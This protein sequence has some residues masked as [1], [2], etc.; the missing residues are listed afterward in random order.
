M[1]QDQC[2][3]YTGFGAL[4]STLQAI[5]GGVSSNRSYNASQVEAAI[6]A[7]EAELAAQSIFLDPCAKLSKYACKQWKHAKA[8]LDPLG[9]PYLQVQLRVQFYV[10]SYLFLVD[11][12]ARLHY[13]LQLRRNLLDYTLSTL[14]IE[15]AFLLASIALQADKG[16]QANQRIPSSSN[17]TNVIC[18]SSALLPTD[19]TIQGY[20]QPSDYL[21]SWLLAEMGDEYVLRHLPTMHADQSGLTSS[22]AQLL[23]IKEVSEQAPHNLHMYRLFRHS[24]GHSHVSHASDRIWLGICSTGVHLFE[25]DRSGPS[26][27]FL[28]S[29]L[30]TF[31]WPD[32]GKL[33]FEKRKF[34]IRS[35]GYP[36]RKFTYFTCSEEMAKHL[37]WLCR[38]SH[39]FQLMIAPRL[40]EMKRRENEL[41]RKRYRESYI[42]SAEDQTK[43]ETS[44]TTRR[45]MSSSAATGR[46][47]SIT[48]A[49]NNLLPNSVSMINTKL[50][51]PVSTNGSSVVITKPEIHSPPFTKLTTNGS[52]TSSVASS[53]HQ[54]DCQSPAL[55]SNSTPSVRPLLHS[56]LPVNSAGAVRSSLESLTISGLSEPIHTAANSYESNIRRS[57]SSARSA[58]NGSYSSDSAFVSCDTTLRH[59][60]NNIRSPPLAQLQSQSF[61]QLLADAADSAVPTPNSIPI[62][63]SDAIQSHLGKSYSPIATATSCSALSGLSPLAKSNGDS[64]RNEM[65]KLRPSGSA[66]VLPSQPSTNCKQSNGSHP[67]PTFASLSNFNASR[68]AYTGNVQQSQK[69]FGRLASASKS[70]PNVSGELFGQTSMLEQTV[71]SALHR[72]QGALTLYQTSPQIGSMQSVFSTSD[73]NPLEAC[74]GN[75]SA[76]CQSQ[77]TVKQNEPV[78]M[79]IS[80]STSSSRSASDSDSSQGRVDMATSPLRQHIY[81]NVPFHRPPLAQTL[82]PVR[83]GPK[84]G[85]SSLTRGM[86]LATH[87]AYQMVNGAGNRLKMQVQNGQISSLNCRP[88]AMENGE[89][90]STQSSAVF[91]SDPNLPNTHIT[92]EVPYKATRALSDPT[93]LGAR[94]LHSSNINSQLIVSN[95]TTNNSSCNT[96]FPAQNLI[97]SR[98]SGRSTDDLSMKRVLPKRSPSTAADLRI[99]RAL[100]GYE[101]V[102]KPA[103]AWARSALHQSLCDLGRPFQG[104]LSVCNLSQIPRSITSNRATLGKAESSSS[105]LSNGG[106][107]D[108]YSVA[109]RMQSRYTPNSMGGS[110]QTIFQQPRQQSFARHP[111]RHAE[112]ELQ[113][114]GSM[115]GS[116]GLQLIPPPPDYASYMNK[117]QRQQLIAASANHLLMNGRLKAT[118]EQQLNQQSHRISEHA[119]RLLHESGKP[120]LDLASLRQR[121]HGLDLPLI[122]ALFN[123]RSLMLPK[124]V[125]NRTRANQFNQ[126][127][128]KRNSDESIGSSST[129]ACLPPHPPKYSFTPSAV[130][131]SPNGSSSS[132]TTYDHHPNHVGNLSLNAHSN[133]LM[134][135]SC[136]DVTPVDLPPAQVQVL[137]LAEPVCFKQPISGPSNAPYS[138]DPHAPLSYALSH[139]EQAD[140]NHNTLN[141]NYNLPTKSLQSRNPT[142]EFIEKLWAEHFSQ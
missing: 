85:V 63:S 115:I 72:T 101:Q 89:R 70:M 142:A 138:T 57:H 109:N 3:W 91:H 26:G 50:S 69:R 36:I 49:V 24:T 71:G 137:P 34:E 116:S 128:Q 37:L 88:N 61:G 55:Q 87:P 41:S 2:R 106:M 111:L 10:D 120:Q 40:R 75:S 47:G 14:T 130:S 30:S 117:Q 74:T 141:C 48:S 27:F 112:S 67:L 1:R 77:S 98:K 121:S 8:G 107:P 42:Y 93:A 35:I 25:Q 132:S 16:D 29:Q 99:N 15:R 76:H 95:A 105:L 134:E 78:A 56:P 59:K 92:S 97:S 140:R 22:E 68:P 113:L 51:S 131:A 139:Q 135:M 9:R 23:F 82:T 62:T 53:S 20:F 90:T 19:P 86:H 54:S 52:G 58:S 108:K 5:T 124:T 119:N 13:Y 46:T 127:K 129:S 73:S 84:I 100:C 123:D 17:L 45:A 60:L 94:P 125:P 64:F 83:V 122:T 81:E 110:S 104:H 31:A 4:S 96:D 114:K 12:V 126:L 133:S 38:V 28:R 32:I 103:L 118:S 65:E 39:Q 11:R 66:A 102:P 44:R 6:Q 7:G 79:I 136:V 18:S 33:F 43:Q 80:G 21:P